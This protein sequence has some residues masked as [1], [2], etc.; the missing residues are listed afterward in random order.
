MEKSLC[1]MFNS[2]VFC[3]TKIIK[4]I[5]YFDTYRARKFNLYNG[6]FIVVF[7]NLICK[8]EVNFPLWNIECLGFSQL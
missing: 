6:I 8:F 7:E 2:K 3:I 5:T 1:N 4:G